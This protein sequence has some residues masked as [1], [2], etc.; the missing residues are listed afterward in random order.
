[1]ILQKL[2]ESTR[3]QHEALESAVDVMNRSLAIEDYKAM[4]VKFY[5]L[6]SALEP[7]LPA[8]ALLANGF[9]ISVRK[10]L[11]LLEKDLKYLGADPGAVDRWSDIPDLVDVARAFGGLYVMEGATLG[12]QVI[13]RHLKQHL[14]IT[15]ETGAAFFNSYGAEVGPMWKQFGAAVTAFSEANGR[16][17]ETVQAARETFDAFRRCFEESASVETAA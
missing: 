13:T 10:K 5:R 2:K 8:D 7:T 1:M 4:L 3:D 14:D 12:G 6:Y 9:D 16:E 15:P 17:G 11:P